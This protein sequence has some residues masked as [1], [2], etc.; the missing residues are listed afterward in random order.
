MFSHLQQREVFHLLFLK[1][2][3]G[4]L[5][6]DSYAVKGGVNL[7]FFF[8]SIRY[9]EG[10]DLDIKGIGSFKLKDIVMDILLSK[11]LSATVRTFN[12]EKIIPPDITKAKQTETTQR[13]KVHLI[14]SAGEDLF[15]R[16]EFSRRKLDQPI[17]TESVSS[18]ILQLYKLSCIIV[19]HYPAQVAITQKISALVH[20][21]EPQARDIFDL[22]LLLPWL[23]ESRAIIDAMPK[24]VIRKAYEH[25]FDID[26]N[27]F[28]NTVL[29]YLSDEEQALYN[30]R[31]V[32][33]EIQLKT[34]HLLEGIGQ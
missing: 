9:S 11:T 8:G 23:K 24:N 31:E 20:R 22:H 26:F 1:Q 7:R 27:V 19:S 30:R 4:K 17:K 28:R 14:N 21:R 3:S 13:F 12:I 5:K 18:V 2:L 34:G 32:W 16:I 29:S 15:T 33:E 6:S 10:M 25:V